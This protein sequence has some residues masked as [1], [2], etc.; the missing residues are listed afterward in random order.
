MHRVFQHS[1]VFFS[2]RHEFCSFFKKYPWNYHLKSIQNNDFLLDFQ[3]K[4]NFKCIRT[5][6]FRIT[7]RTEY[8][9]IVSKNVMYKSCSYEVLVFLYCQRRCEHS[10]YLFIFLIFDPRKYYTLWHY[11]RV[12][13]GG[14]RII[15][16]LSYQILMA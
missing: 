11:R 8:T 3:K 16:I 7:T 14:Y 12:W 10:V 5:Y 2:D 9:A 1:P 13:W 6:S 4:K 15:F